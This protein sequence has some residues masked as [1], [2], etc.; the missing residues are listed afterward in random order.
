MAN[1]RYT[2]IHKVSEANEN[3]MRKELNLFDANYTK[4]KIR[5]MSLTVDKDCFVIINGD[6]I[7]VLAALGLNWELNDTPI[8]S[9]VMETQ[10]VSVYAIIGY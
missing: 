10:G 7:K 3:L 4:P 9:F 1:L 8:H 5:K 2:N 6:R